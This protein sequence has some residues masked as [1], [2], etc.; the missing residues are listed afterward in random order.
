MRR[1]LYSLLKP[2]AQDDGVNIL[3]N[4]F[5]TDETSELVKIIRQTGRP[6][7]D[8]TVCKT[9]EDYQKMA[10]SA[11]HIAYNPPAKAGGE[12]L[13]NRLGGTFLYLPLS[14]TAKTIRRNPANALRGAR[15]KL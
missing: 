15:N 10:A 5:P 9:Y 3:G 2:R 11:L 8:I 13:S 7:R 6:L 1:Q 14:H 12:A 4:C